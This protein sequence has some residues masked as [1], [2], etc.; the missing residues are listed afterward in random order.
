MLSPFSIKWIY[1]IERR[2]FGQ[3]YKFSNKNNMVSAWR[4]FKNIFS[5]PLFTVIYRPEM[6]K[7]HPY[8]ILTVDKMVGFVIFC[9][10]ITF[11]PHFVHGFSGFVYSFW[12]FCPLSLAVF[13]VININFA[14]LFTFFNVINKKIRPPCLFTPSCS[15]IWYLREYFM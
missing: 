13:H 15:F 10:L 9:V 6:L 7:L 12:S 14:P 2:S 5:R 3:K 4:N 8:S 11:L 1:L